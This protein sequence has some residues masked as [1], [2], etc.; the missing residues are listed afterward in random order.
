M[1]NEMELVGG[2]ALGEMHF[3]TISV[4]WC[5]TFDKLVFFG[6]VILGFKKCN[7]L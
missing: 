6:F 4:C 3:L 5:C 7:C 2:A 1:D